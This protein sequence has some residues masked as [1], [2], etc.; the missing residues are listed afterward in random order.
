MKI[1]KLIAVLMTI[2]IIWG[3]T[4]PLLP[5]H[6]APMIDEDSEMAKKALTTTDL[7]AFS[8]EFMAQAMAEFHVPGAALVVVQ[9]DRVLLSKGFGYANLD[10][11][12]PLTPATPTRPAS[13]AKT[14]AF[15]TILQ[16]YD[17]GRLEFSDSVNQH[18]SSPLLHDTFAPMSIHNFLTHTEGFED[19]TVGVV[20]PSDDE[21]LP[22]QTHFERTSPGR[23]MPPGEMITYGNFG[24]VL[25]SVLTEQISGQTFADYTAEN[26][27]QPLGMTRTTFA[28]PM[29]AE[30][31]ANLGTE[32]ILEDGNPQPAP[33]VY[34]NVAAG[35]GITSSA[36]DMGKFM[37]VLLQNGAYE[38]ARLL[39]EETASMMLTQQFSGHPDLPGT[40]YGF[41]EHFENG[42]RAVRRDGYGLESRSRIFLIPEEGVGIYLYY[43]V[44]ENELRNAF[45]SQFLDEFYPAA[46]HNTTP[47]NSDNAHLDGVYAAVQT[48]NHTYG[49]LQAIFAGVQQVRHEDDGSMTLTP[50]N[51]DAYG[52]I[53]AESHW[54]EASPLFYQRIDVDEGSVAFR[55]TDGETYLFMGTGMLG[56]YRKM[57]W[58][59]TPLFQGGLATAS[60][61]MFVATLVVGTIGWRRAAQTSETAGQISPLAWG[62]S[63]AVSVAALLF[64]SM[65]FYGIFVHQ[66]MLP[67]LPAYAFGTS[68]LL[69]V[70]LGFSFLVVVLVVAFTAVTTASVDKGFQ[71]AGKAIFSGRV[72]VLLGIRLALA[73]LEFA[74][75]SLLTSVWGLREIPLCQRS[76]KLEPRPM[77]LR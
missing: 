48:D 8:D 19:R 11:Q 5:V 6:A 76:A 73:L 65:A 69:K 34:P 40:T 70:I 74:R 16:L 12:I 20:A 47:A 58:Y 43:N 54:S 44:G 37:M 7:E 13:L 52:G 27:F 22:I 46:P 4:M 45:F 75:S 61:L 10:A 71:L 26:I 41:M 36:E 49:K 15:M 63:L 66:S 57:A 23:I 30:L 29:P 28:Q 64:L 18:L 60:L 2:T 72:L 25:A 55:E 62:L 68:P 9:N 67:L 59:E 33:H 31:F 42:Q 39:E 17:Q 51:F 21:I 38:G 50:L 3:M 35:G 32:Y 53:E 56:A 14:F 1:E 24:S 77:I